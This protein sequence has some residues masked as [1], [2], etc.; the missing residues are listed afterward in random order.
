MYKIYKYK[1][2]HF[3]KLT[4]LSYKELKFVTPLLPT[5]KINPFSDGKKLSCFC[6]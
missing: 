1:H 5:G 3:H 6:F 4:S 2:Q